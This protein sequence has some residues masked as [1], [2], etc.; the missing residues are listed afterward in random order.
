MFG[1][2]AGQSKLMRV[3]GII[4]I[5]AFAVVF[6]KNFEAFVYMVIPPGKV[7]DAFLHAPVEFTVYMFY[8]YF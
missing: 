3:L 8:G 6:I 7:I 4:G 1:I 5:V 2:K